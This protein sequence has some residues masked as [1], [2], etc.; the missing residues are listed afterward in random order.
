MLMKTQKNQVENFQAIRI[1]FK[2][3]KTFSNKT[4]LY[5]ITSSES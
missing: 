3:L 4:Y 1:I 2:A 5:F